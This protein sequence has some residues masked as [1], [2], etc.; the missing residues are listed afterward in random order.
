MAVYISQDGF[1]EG[2]AKLVETFVESQLMPPVTKRIEHW[3][4]D[5]KPLLSE[6]Q[7]MGAPPLL[8]LTC[9]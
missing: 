2:V 9:Y 3:Q 1:D 5:R 4:R 7:V 8:R 6:N